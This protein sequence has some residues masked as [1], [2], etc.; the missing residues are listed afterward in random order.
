[1]RLSRVLSNEHLRGQRRHPVAFVSSLTVITAYVGGQEQ[2]SGNS[3][4]VDYPAAGLGTVSGS[5]WTVCS[6]MARRGS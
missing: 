3:V 4:D 6:N 1:M 2:E 5:S